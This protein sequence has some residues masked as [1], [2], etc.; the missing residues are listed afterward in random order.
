MKF[1]SVKMDI[2]Q[3]KA[4][5]VWLNFYLLCGSFCKLLRR[6]NDDRVLAGIQRFGQIDTLVNNAGYGQYGI[7][8]AVT[9][10]QIQAQFDTNVFGVMN[11]M[12]ATVPYLRNRGNG[13]IVNI[14]SAGGRCTP[15]NIHNNAASSPKIAAGCFYDSDI[16]IYLY[17]AFALYQH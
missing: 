1:S 7:F 11:V 8:E 16:I 10:E 15:S 9:S 6:L 4:F 2:F 12:W 13:M 17:P 3:G 14:S 5:A